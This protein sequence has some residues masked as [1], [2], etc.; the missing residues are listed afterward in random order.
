MQKENAVMEDKLS[1]ATKESDSLRKRLSAV[2]ESAHN[3]EVSQLHFDKQALETKLQ[4]LASQCQRLSSEMSGMLQV[5]HA[6]RLDFGASDPSDLPAAIVKLC[7]KV[8]SLEKERDSLSKTD[9]RDSATARKLRELQEHIERLQKTVVNSRA[10]MEKLTQSEASLKQTLSRLRQEH[11]ERREATSALEKERGHVR[12][13][14]QENLRLMMDIKEKKKLNQQLKSELI[15]RRIQGSDDTV[16]LGGGT[17]RVSDQKYKDSV[18]VDKENAVNSGAPL[19]TSETR[20]RQ[21]LSI[22]KQSKSV[23]R[24]GD[25]TGKDHQRVPGLDISVQDNEESTHECNQS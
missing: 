17:T 6:S 23:P 16:D 13:L 24:V 4:K 19:R 12:Y 10:E 2:S 25:V 9:E 7:D 1:T 11:E 5:L 21:P 20:T 8:T 14:E 18:P 22:R 15:M 3:T